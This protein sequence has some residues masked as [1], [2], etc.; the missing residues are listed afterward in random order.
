MNGIK[1]EMNNQA[2]DGLE[3]PETEFV[4]LSTWQAEMRARLQLSQG[5]QI[6]NPKRSA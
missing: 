1:V 2:E 4:E 5:H 6:L 3:A